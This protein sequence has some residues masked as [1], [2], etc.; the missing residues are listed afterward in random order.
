MRKIVS[1][2]SKV[3]IFISAY[4]FRRI[5]KMISTQSQPH[6]PFIKAKKT[7]TT[8]VSSFTKENITGIV[9]QK[10]DYT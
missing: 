10:L 5:T 6:L 7:I 3:F 2:P 4:L 8:I 1:L 9:F